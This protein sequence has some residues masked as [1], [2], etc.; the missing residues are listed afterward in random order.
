[1]AK[2]TRPA[3]KPEDQNGL[4]EAIAAADKVVTIRGIIRESGASPAFG[5]TKRVLSSV[6]KI[7]CENGSA[8]IVNQ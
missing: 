3:V 6:A 5:E 1:M 8:E 7:L 2:T 4:S